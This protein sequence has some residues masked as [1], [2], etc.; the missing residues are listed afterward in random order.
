MKQ[1]FKFS[2]ASALGV[3]IAVVVLS[4]IWLLI[5]IGIASST[6][7]TPKLQ[8]NTLLKLELKGILSD[9]G[10]EDPF[11]EIINE[12]SGMDQ[13]ANIGL[14]EILAAIEKAKNNENICGI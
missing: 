4:L 1:F 6:E 3:V 8:N 5:L 7:S 11:T 12:L 13:A 14:D 9:Y 2:L 10:Q